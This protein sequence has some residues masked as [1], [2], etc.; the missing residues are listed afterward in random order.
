MSSEISY[1]I[2]LALV[3]YV[4]KI[5]IDRVATAE[6]FVFGT[7]DKISVAYTK[8]RRKLKRSVDRFKA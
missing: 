5:I 1:I 7:I 3:I 6:D 2:A 8:Y 4:F